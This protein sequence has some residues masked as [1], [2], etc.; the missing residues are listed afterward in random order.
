MRIDVGIENLGKLVDGGIP[1]GNSIL[2]IGN[3]GTGK[4]I[5]SLQYLVSGI[6]N[7]GEPGILVSFVDDRKSI[8]RYA[9]QFNWQT[10]RLEN[11]GT[12]TILGGSPGRLEGFSTGINK[13]NE[14]VDELIEKIKETGAERLAI[15]GID[16]FSELFD[17]KRDFKAAISKLRSEL[18]ENKVTSVMTSKPGIGIE[19][20]VDGIIILHY[21]GDIEK[22]RAIE[23]IK[24]RGS[25]HTDRMCPLE[26]TDEGI[27]VTGPPEDEG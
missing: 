25:R 21:D 11:E 23:V 7:Q 8:H 19:E 10:K 24:M 22:T 9:K 2:L 14:I 15:D 3:Y 1:Q 4:T 12:L 26:I 5:F 18:C 27:I 6:A 20:V 16:E 13:T 17:N